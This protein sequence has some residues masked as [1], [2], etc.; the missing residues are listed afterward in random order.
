MSYPEDYATAAEQELTSVL[1]SLRQFPRSHESDLL[2]EHEQGIGHF[3][4]IHENAEDRFVPVVSFISHGL[5]RDE[6]ILCLTTDELRENLLTAMRAGGIDVDIALDSGSLSVEPISE[7]SSEETPGETTVPVKRLEQITE[8]TETDEEVRLITQ[9]SAVCSDDPNRDDIVDYE[10][11]LTH[12]CKELDAISLC[13]YDRTQFPSALLRDVIRLHPYLLTDTTASQNI[14]FAPPDDLIGLGQPERH[15]QRML[16]TVQTLTGTKT[17]LMKK[18]EALQQ[19]DEQ[20]RLALE[21]G[22]L[23]IW[24]LDLQ[25]ET[26]PVRSL[27]HDQIFGYDNPPDDWGF[28]HFLE[29]VHPSDHERVKRSFDAALESGNWSFECRIVRVDGAERWVAVDGEI[30]YDREGTPIKAIGVIKDI[31]ERKDL[32][33]ELRTE[34]EHFRLALENSPFTAFRLDTDLRYTWI[35]SPHDDF[36]PEGIIGK[37][38]DELLPPGAAE[39]VMEPKRRV[40]ETGEGVREEL[41]YELPSGTVS[42]DLTVEPLHDESGEIIG[43]T[44]AALDITERKQHQRELE[45]TI[46][47]LEETNQRLEQFAYAASH[48]LQ[49]PLR[50]VSSYLRLIEQRY[51]DAF[52]KDGEEFLSYAINGADRMR[53]MIE[54]LLAYSRVET[55]GEPLEPVDLET[56]FENACEDVQVQIEESNAE[57]QKEHLPCVEGDASQLRQLYQ[58]LLSNAIKYS[59]DEP[60]QIHVGAERRDDWWQISVADEGVGIDPDEHEYIFE[61]FNRLHTRE[62]HPGS[63][64]GLALCQRIIERHGGELWVKSEPGLGSTFSFTLPTSE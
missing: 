38:D 58:N 55:E 62:E 33:R 27:R 26:A 7:I 29:H 53:E 28:E 14:Y 40:L 23:G 9:M 6:Q 52:D 18:E 21:A 11:Q 20:L 10:H 22:D 37:R 35:G 4:S 5:E 61:I 34:K 1:Q 42:Y 60:P 64:I 47:Q 12:A 54:G 17:T 48:D 46:S 2:T 41:T 43:L 63:G 45:D 31:T 13:L 24:E 3:A 16:D 44:C 8:D 59:G 56:V 49:E 39:T 25:S 57:I 50:M 19:T 15:V 32:E 51:A 30:Y 36:D